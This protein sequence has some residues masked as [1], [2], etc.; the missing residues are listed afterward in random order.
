AVGAEKARALEH[1]QDADEW[2]ARGLLDAVFPMNYTDDAALFERRLADWQS[3]AG[4]TPLGLGVMLQGRAGEVR[5][6]ELRRAHEDV[7]A[8]ALFGYAALFDSR[9]TVLESQDDAARAAR[10]KRRAR[11]LPYLRGFSRG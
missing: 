2:L 6:G 11:L 3:R 5:I 7:G 1:F 10:A 4:R 9:N 8:F